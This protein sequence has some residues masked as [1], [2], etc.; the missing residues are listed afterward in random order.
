MKDKILECFL[1][2]DSL[3]FNEIEKNVGVRSNKLSYHLTKLVEQGILSKDGD[4]Y[5]L[6]EDF[7]NLIPYISNKKHV[8]SVILVHVGDSA[9]AFLI[10]RTKRPYLNK[11]ALPGGRIVMGES[12][13]DGAARILK[14]FGAKM[15]EFCG[16]KSVSVEHLKRKDKIIA[17]YLLVYVGAKADAELTDLEKNKKRI[18][19]SDYLLMKG[20]FDK[21]VRIKT[22]DSV[23]D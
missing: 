13:E 15:K 22:I 19:E 23:V 16:V 17:S 8:L 21:E 14:K 7:E 20:D 18:V 6:T 4:N 1:Y 5:T 11:L 10:K 2:A 3:K 9:S 12:L